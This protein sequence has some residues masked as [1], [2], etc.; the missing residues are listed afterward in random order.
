MPDFI[1]KVA[2]EMDQDSG[3]RSP[4]PAE[5]GNSYLLSEGPK[6]DDLSIDGN[7]IWYRFSSSAETGEASPEGV[8]LCPLAES[9]PAGM[10]TTYCYCSVGYVKESFELRFDR[11]VDVEL[12]DSVL[13]GGKR[14]SFKITVI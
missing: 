14:C 6:R 10:S 13:K 11:K 3:F 9:K 5:K 8:C 12:T 1:K 7:V 2:S 4:W